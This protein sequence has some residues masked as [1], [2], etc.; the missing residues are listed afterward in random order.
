MLIYIY[1]TLGKCADSLGCCQ[2]LCK[3]KE[4]EM[5]AGE[6]YNMQSRLK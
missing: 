3:K 6:N 2:V 5:V 4:K 1:Y